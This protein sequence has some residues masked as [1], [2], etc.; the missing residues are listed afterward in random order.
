MRR[1]KFTIVYYYL[2]IASSC[3]IQAKH[4]INKT[5]HSLIY[6][7][8]SCNDASAFRAYHWVAL[9]FGAKHSLYF[10]SYWPYSPLR[11]K[12]ITVVCVV[13]RTRLSEFVTGHC[14]HILSGAVERLYITVFLIQVRGT[15]LLLIDLDINF[16]FHFKNPLMD[17]FGNF[18]YTMFA[19]TAG[20]PVNFA[21]Y[22][23]VS[24]C[25]STWMG[26][27][28]CTAAQTTCQS[29]GGHLVHVNS[30]EMSN[31]LVTFFKSSPGMS[32]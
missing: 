4:C 22:R 20:C 27:S 12:I 19:T 1:L 21:L 18:L 2:L 23:P 8:T 10:I 30:Q 24:L 29:H 3:L 11:V 28:D 25:Y 7:Y 31:H 17:A 13:Y 5:L 26:F 6:R 14:G 16:I 15:G 32:C 9:V